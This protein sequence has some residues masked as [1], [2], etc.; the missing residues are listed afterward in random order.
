MAAA[1][2]TEDIPVF[3]SKNRITENDQIVVT[4]GDAVKYRLYDRDHT[5]VWTSSG[6][7]GSTC[8]I[9]VQFTDKGLAQARVFDT[10]FVMGTNG[11]SFQYQVLPSAGGAWAPMTSLITGSGGLASGIL[12]NTLWNST[13]VGL[14]GFRL[15]VSTLTA[16]EKTI[17]EI[18][19]L[20]TLYTP[21]RHA[22]T[23]RHNRKPVVISNLGV[24]GT[25]NTHLIRW[26]GDKSAKW[27]GELGWTFASDTDRAGFISL[28]DEG[29]FVVYPE[30]ESFP[31][32][33]YT[34]RAIDN[35]L[36]YEY[37]NTFKGAGHSLTLKMEEV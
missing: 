18:Y 16:V 24:D 30:P 23:L 26:A 17:G 22:D 35:A 31:N 25:K 32:E 27:N 15:Y 33:I 3:F 5:T 8:L 4:S 28:Y 37:S 9:E 14:Y 6:E 7:T 12:R 29:E 13:T 21:S 36:A 19:L 20:E 34:V 11:T 1:F 2:T 10:L